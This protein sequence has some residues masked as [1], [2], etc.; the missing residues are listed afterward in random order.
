MS[1]HATPALPADGLAP[2]GPP[3]ASPSLTIEPAG[4]GTRA[5]W[6]GFVAAQ[7]GSFYHLYDWK[8]VNERSLGHHCEYLMARGAGG[9]IEGV[10][11]LV[12]VKSRLFGRILCSM[13]F[14]NYGGP[15]TATPVAAS[16]L[17]RHAMS[18]A[19]AL[20][21][22]Y[23]ELRCP[24]P[25]DTQMP[26]SLR[27]VSMTVPLMPD[28]EALFASFSQKHRKN[29]RR[30]QKNNLE[31]RKG[32]IDL[33]DDFFG[34]LELSWRSLGT[35]MY[36]RSYFER[37]LKTFPANTSVFTCSHQGKPVAVALTGHFNGVVE[38]MWA[39]ARQELRHLDANYVLYWEML[40]DAC[41]TGHKLFHLGRSTSQ[42]GAE[43]FKS[44]WNA[45]TH[46]LYWYFH[47]PDGGPMPQLNVDNPKYQLAIAA[48]RR[49]PLPATRLIGPHLARLIP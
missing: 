37:I 42:S 48:W 10:L 41:Q 28:A 35:P 30:A 40:R 12:F 34:I 25:L 29:I 27:K 43:Q 47:R 23:L 6:D 21:A 24:S 5:A 15:V 18:R 32:G 9:A 7:N 11:P 31:V 33:L 36:S 14:M 38:G 46:Q 3:S 45:E 20:G 49:L 4:A 26:V 16:E 44:K 13:P 1:S 22:D 8:D 17:T 39:G 2:S 19:K